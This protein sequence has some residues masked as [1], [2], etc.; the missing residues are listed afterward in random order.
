M[1]LSDWGG[2]GRKYTPVP[3]GSPRPAPFFFYLYRVASLCVRVVYPHALTYSPTGSVGVSVRQYMPVG[4]CLPPALLVPEV[5][6]LLL[7]CFI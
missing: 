3:L 6:A 2:T 1:T 7:K 4:F 5:P